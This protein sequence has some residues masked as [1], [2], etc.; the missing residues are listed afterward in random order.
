MF[1]VLVLYWMKARWNG[2][3]WIYSRPKRIGKQNYSKTKQMNLKSVICSC[4]KTPCELTG[5]TKPDPCSPKQLISHGWLTWNTLPPS[6]SIQFRRFTITKIAY[7][8]NISSPIQKFVRKWNRTFLMSEK[9]TWKST[10]IWSFVS[11]IAPNFQLRMSGQAEMF[12][13]K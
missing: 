4:Y 1:R 13:K 5:K 7:D 12:M 6:R 3:S 2:Q 10:S 11:A 9:F 8:F